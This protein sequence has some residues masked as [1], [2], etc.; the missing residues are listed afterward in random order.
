MPPVLLAFFILIGAGA[1]SALL[2]HRP[3]T[4]GEKL[5]EPARGFFTSTSAAYYQVATRDVYRREACR[6]VVFGVSLGQREVRAQ[7]DGVEMGLDWSFSKDVD[8]LPATRREVVVRYLDPVGGAELACQTVSFT[9]VP[10]AWDGRIRGTESNAAPCSEAAAEGKGIDQTGPPRLEFARPARAM[11]T[12]FVPGYDVL[13]GSVTFVAEIR[14]AIDERWYCPRVEWEFPLEPGPHPAQ[15]VRSSHES[16]CDPFVPGA[17]TER[18]FVVRR[19]LPEG[20]WT[21][22]VRLWKGDELLSQQSQ[23][24]VV[25]NSG[26]DPW[27]TNQG[28]Y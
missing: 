8:A 17:K 13:L 26:G 28:G 6:A 24:V 14:G 27:R 16:D 10:E 2:D 7:I 21:V 15:T 19:V 9:C 25:G 1:G 18:R 20:E 11:A 5:G 22:T 23:T 4:G 3:G 12:Q